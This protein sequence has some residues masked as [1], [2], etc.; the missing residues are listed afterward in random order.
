MHKIKVIPDEAIE[1]LLPD[2]T[3]MRIEAT[4]KNGAPHSV[5]IINPLGHPDNPMQDA[6]IEEKFRGLAEA[7]LGS[8]RCRAALEGWWRIDEADDV[9]A[10]IRLLDIQETN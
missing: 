10:L 1:A 8:I 6:H 4:T 3:L 9:S 2:K 5:A 7:V